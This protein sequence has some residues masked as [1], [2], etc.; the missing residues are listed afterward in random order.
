MTIVGENFEQE[1]YDLK[2][3]I[4]QLQAQFKIKDYELD[5][6]RDWHLDREIEAA[7]H[8]QYLEADDHRRRR[9]EIFVELKR[10]KEAIKTI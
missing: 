4:A 5:A 1:V 7:D 3:Q 9:E 8:Q 10:R 6:L 2:L